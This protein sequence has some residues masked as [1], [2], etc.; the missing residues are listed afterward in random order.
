MTAGAFSATG[1]A[2]GSVTVP[3]AGTPPCLRVQP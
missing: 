1:A 2:P 3:R